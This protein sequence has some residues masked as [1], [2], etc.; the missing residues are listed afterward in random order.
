[1]LKSLALVFLLMAICHL[2]A[3]LFNSQ[4]NGGMAL[5]SS[6]Q[7]IWTSLSLANQGFDRDLVS[8]DGCRGDGG[9]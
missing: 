7:N 2:P 1:M 3:F 4:G 6:K 8:F 5:L 9:T